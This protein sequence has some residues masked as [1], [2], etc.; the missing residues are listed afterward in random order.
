MVNRLGPRGRS[1]LNPALPVTSSGNTG[2]ELATLSKFQFPHLHG[3][4]QPPRM[5]MEMKRQ[6]Y[7]QLLTHRKFPINCGYLLF[8]SFLKFVYENK[9]KRSDW[10]RAC[11]LAFG[12][13]L[14]DTVKR[15]HGMNTTLGENNIIL[16]LLGHRCWQTHGN[17]SF[18]LN[19]SYFSSSNNL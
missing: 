2:K 18:P 10:D 11:R 6:Y 3:A 12:D 7:T 14:S 15:D 4:S 9:S 19:Y 16:V 17:H 13:T 8:L 5:V 1:C